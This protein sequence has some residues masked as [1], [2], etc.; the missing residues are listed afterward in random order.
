[1]EKVDLLSIFTSEVH[2]NAVSTFFRH[3]GN[4]FFQQLEIF[5]LRNFGS[6]IYTFVAFKKMKI[7]KSPRRFTPCDYLCNIIHWL[8]TFSLNPF[9]VYLDFTIGR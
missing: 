1:M 3:E 2:W 6:W 7:N 5:I 8:D 4:D 9:D